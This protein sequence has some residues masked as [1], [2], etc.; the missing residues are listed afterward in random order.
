MGIQ[1]KIQAKLAKALDG[2]L[3][4]A[5]STLVGSYKG[6]GVR[7]PVEGTTTAVTITYTGRGVVYDVDLSRI[8]GLNFMT[9]DAQAVILA[10][11]VT[12]APGVG[13]FI[14]ARGAKYLVMSAGMDPA[15]ATY[16]LHLRRV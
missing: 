4:D 1:S 12:E 13:H 15:L 16:T 8:D 10:N 5:V 14:T 9:G 6:P 7:D 11:E 2:K 3:S